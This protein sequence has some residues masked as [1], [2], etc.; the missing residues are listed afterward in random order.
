MLRVEADDTN[1]MLE[2]N[3]V[4]KALHIS[5]IFIVCH[6]IFLSQ[7]NKFFNSLSLQVLSGPKYHYSNYALCLCDWIPLNRVA[8]I[9]NQEIMRGLLQRKLEL[10]PHDHLNQVLDIWESNMIGWTVCEFLYH[11]KIPWGYNSAVTPQG[12]LL[13]RWIH[14]FPSFA[15]FDYFWRLIQ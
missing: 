6:L 10:K 7:M 15:P 11:L 1:W 5:S 9:D 2:V 14:Q 8:R 4:F 13:Q 12:T 3:A